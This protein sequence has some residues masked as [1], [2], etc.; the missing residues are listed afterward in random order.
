MC[1]TDFWDWGEAPTSAKTSAMHDNGL[2]LKI[3]PNPFRTSVDILVRSPSHVARHEVRLEVFNIAGKMV[4]SIKS[5]ATLVPHSDAGSDE[6]LA[7]SYTWHPTGQPGGIYI[8]Q[9]KVGDR[10][11]TKKATLVK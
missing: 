2:E 11:L 3:G 6:R 4:A 10:V 1:R 7:T 8:F 9:A 5:R